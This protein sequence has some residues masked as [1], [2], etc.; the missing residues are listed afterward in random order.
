MLLK[1]LQNVKLVNLIPRPYSTQGTSGTGDTAGAG[2]SASVSASASAGALNIESIDCVGTID[3][4]DFTI[5]VKSS[6]L[7]GKSC[8]IPVKSGR[9]TYYRL[10][11]PGS[12]I[13]WLPGKL[14][15]KTGVIRS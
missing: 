12:S 15:D 1:S 11:S 7:R 13:T 10:H 2:A 4:P 6:K 8:L 5:S 9:R 14:G 3:A